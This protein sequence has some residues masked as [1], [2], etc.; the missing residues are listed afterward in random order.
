[1][2]AGARFIAAEAALDKGFQ[3]PDLDQEALVALLQEAEAAR[4]ALR[5][6]HLSRHLMTTEILTPDQ[7]AR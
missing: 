1:V 5:L 3:S 2:A 4:S 7:V 6:V